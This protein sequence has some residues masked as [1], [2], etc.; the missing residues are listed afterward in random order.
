MDLSLFK[1]VVDS[2]KNQSTKSPVYYL[3]K[4]YRMHP[5]ILKFP[6]SRF[7]NNY[8]KTEGNFRHN[9]LNPYMVFDLQTNQNLT[10]NIER[11]VYNS[12]EI[13]FVIDLLKIILAIPESGKL[14]YGVITPYGRNRIELISAFE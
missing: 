3:K 13:G 5:E 9:I 6:N 7:Y 2:F 1:R 4:Q 8:L 14:S 12:E 10:Q 11:N